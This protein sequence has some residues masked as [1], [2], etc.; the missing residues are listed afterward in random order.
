MIESR[1][2]VNPEQTS[3]GLSCAQPG[4]F[5]VLSVPA[6]WLMR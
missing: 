4:A 5:F 1:F 2:P 6:L 3:A